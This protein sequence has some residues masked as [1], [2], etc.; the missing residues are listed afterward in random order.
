MT[1]IQSRRRVLRQL[2]GVGVFA[3][4]SPWHP[5]LAALIPTPEQTAMARA[6]WP[7][8]TTAAMPSTMSAPDELM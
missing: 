2:S 5:A 4:A 1:P 7:H 6:A 8:P 3:L